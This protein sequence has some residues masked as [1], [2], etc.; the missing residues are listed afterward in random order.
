MSKDV[1]QSVVERTSTRGSNER[2]SMMPDLK[3]DARKRSAIRKIAWYQ[4]LLGIV[5]NR[6]GG[7]TQ[8][9]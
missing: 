9:T 8:K 6:A 7:F 2:S 4:E 5:L 1:I 3:V